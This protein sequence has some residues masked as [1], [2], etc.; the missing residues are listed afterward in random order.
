MSQ[1]SF[2][3]VNCNTIK[4][5]TMMV[6]LCIILVAPTLLGLEVWQGLRRAIAPT[7]T[8]L[9]GMF[10]P[11]KENQWRVDTQIYGYINFL[12]FFQRNRSR[13]GGSQWLR[14]RHFLISYTEWSFVALCG[15]VVRGVRPISSVS[16]ERPESAIFRRWRQIQRR[17]ENFTVGGLGTTKRSKFNMV[18]FRR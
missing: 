6:N 2:N 7:P 16:I 8:C 4:T 3:N 10:F 11:A 18:N 5:A 15:A 9:F 13:A 1:H 14:L 17:K 12:C